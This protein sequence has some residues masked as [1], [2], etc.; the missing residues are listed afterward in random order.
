MVRSLLELCV[1]KCVRVEYLQGAG[2]MQLHLK[3]LQNILQI[4]QKMKEE[5]LKKY[6][7]SIVKIL[8]HLT[9]SITEI[10]KYLIAQFLNGLP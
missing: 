6:T 2:A 5:I 10:K 3:I 4:F 9:S 1:R 7:W 8:N